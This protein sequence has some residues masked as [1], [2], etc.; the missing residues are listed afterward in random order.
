[1]LRLFS[2]L[3]NLVQLLLHHPF[4]SE[5]DLLKV[6]GQT[7]INFQQAY[8]FCQT[9]HKHTDDSYNDLIQP[10][11]IDEFEDED[12]PEENIPN[13]R[14]ALVNQLPGQHSSSSETQLGLRPHD[15]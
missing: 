4:R 1:M 8:D 5:E 10:R 9:H 15:L 6:N 11:G 14:Q 3:A 7:F 12:I 13:S 2:L